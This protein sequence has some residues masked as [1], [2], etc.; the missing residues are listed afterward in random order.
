MKIFD[1]FTASRPADVFG[2]ILFF[3][4]VVGFGH[5]MRLVCIGACDRIDACS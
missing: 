4:P 2:M 5:T 3:S 1:D